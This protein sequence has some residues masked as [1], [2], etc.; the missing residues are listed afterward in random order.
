ML[1]CERQT[2]S[3]PRSV[4]IIQIQLAVSKFF[5]PFFFFF[6]ANLTDLLLIENLRVSIDNIK[7]LC[8]IKSILVYEAGD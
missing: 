8:V 4:K 3:V 2:I 6:L 7:I 1:S 5:F